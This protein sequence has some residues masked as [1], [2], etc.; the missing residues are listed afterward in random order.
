MIVIVMVVVLIG[1]LNLRLRHWLNWGVKVG[2]VNEVV[3]VPVGVG[4][5]R[6]VRGESP[7]VVNDKLVLVYALLEGHHH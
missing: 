3:H 6:L 5:C 4:G 2:R 1:L 7:L